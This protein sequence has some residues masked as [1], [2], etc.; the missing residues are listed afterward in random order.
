MA[1]FE[2]LFDAS[3]IF[4]KRQ[5]AIDFGFSFTQKI[6]IRAVDDEVSQSESKINFP[7]SFNK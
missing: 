6:Q 2:L 1:G 4:F 5:F 7:S 3:K